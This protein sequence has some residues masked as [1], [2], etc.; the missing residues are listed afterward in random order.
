MSPHSTYEHN[1]I[2]EDSIRLLY[3]RPG[4]GNE[5]INCNLKIFNRRGPIPKYE[6]LSC[7]LGSEPA[8][9][10]VQVEGKSFYT[11]PNLHNGLRNLRQHNS[12]NIFWI[13][14]TWIDQKN[15]WEKSEQVMIIAEIYQNAQ[16]M[17]I[18][19]GEKDSDS[20]I[21]MDFV[22]KLLD[23][24]FLSDDNWPGTYARG[25]M[26]SLVFWS[27]LGFPEFGSS[28]RSPTQGRSV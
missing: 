9:H 12:T 18:W 14:A 23:P 7:V 28:K 15:S 6:A 2:K 10:E 22:P 3:L 25:F 11:G 13:N 16:S 27:G 19:L 21:A 1:A 4:S 8:V 20:D 24:S 5:P 17:V 26:L